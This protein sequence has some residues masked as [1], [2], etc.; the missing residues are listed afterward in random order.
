MMT[1]NHPRQWP[2]RNPEAFLATFRDALER[3]D[4]LFRER[5]PARYSLMMDTDEDPER[6]IELCMEAARRMLASP[7]PPWERTT[8]LFSPEER[9]P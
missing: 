8:P 6:F 2:M 7:I 1:S 5:E 4:A 3:A 9:R